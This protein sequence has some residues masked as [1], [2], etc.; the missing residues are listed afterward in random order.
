MLILDPT[1]H[2]EI[3]VIRLNHGLYLTPPDKASDR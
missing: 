2:P 1:R 3:N